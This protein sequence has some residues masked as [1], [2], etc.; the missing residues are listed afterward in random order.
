MD[1]AYLFKYII[2]GDMGVGKSCLMMRFIE[3][4]FRENHDI[5]IGV[6]FGSKKVVNDDQTIK[7]Q[8]WDTAG[9]ENFRSLTRS[10]YRAAVGALLVYDV[11]RRDTF[12]LLEKWIHEVKENSAAHLT[13]LL[14]GNKS[15]CEDEREVS[16]FEGEQFAKEHGLLFLETSAKTGSYVDD[17]FMQMTK[18]VHEKV[19]NKEIDLSNEACGVRMGSEN[20]VILKTK[21]LKEDAKKINES[22]NCAC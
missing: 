11:T 9:Q 1:Y 2:T 8:I 3:G 15:D 19:K 18:I 17:V 10:Y 20:P 22:Q 13:M 5:T 7:L 4:K 16:F 6:E 12:L 14:I 21:P